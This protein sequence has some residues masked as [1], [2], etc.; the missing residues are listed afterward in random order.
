M[1]FDPNNPAAS[2]MVLTFD[3]EFSS[4]TGQISADNVADKTQ[5]SNHVWWEAPPAQFGGSIHDG[6]L[7][8][9]T[10][11]AEMNTINSAGQGFGQ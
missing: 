7:D 3:D 6:V 5:W 4:A 2:G 8:L 11:W 9:N 10:A 1:A